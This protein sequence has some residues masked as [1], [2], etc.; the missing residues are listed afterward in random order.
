M[1]TITSMFKKSVA[2]TAVIVLSACSSS[3]VQL[4]PEG[5]QV[6]VATAAQVASCARVGTA[7]VNALDNIAFVQRGAAKLQ[8]EL[9]MLARNEAAVLGGNRVTPES[10]ITDGRQ[11]F[12][13]YRC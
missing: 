10:T 7:N 4:S 5:R 13:V 9:E 6:I 8:E 3:W 11:S 1:L 2:A 12:G